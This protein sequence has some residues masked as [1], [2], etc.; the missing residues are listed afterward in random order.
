MIYLCFFLFLKE[1]RMIDQFKLYAKGGDGGS[2]CSS[3]HRSLKDRRGKPDG[4]F[5]LSSQ[6][7]V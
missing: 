7:N 4:G 3:V 6:V 5:S 2:G 1:R